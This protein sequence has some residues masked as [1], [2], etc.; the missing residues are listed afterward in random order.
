MR[1]VSILVHAAFCASTATAA[2]NS[3]NA[4]S[5]SE[6]AYCDEFQMPLVLSAAFR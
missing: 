4:A 2:W 3:P 5:N 6:E 1:I